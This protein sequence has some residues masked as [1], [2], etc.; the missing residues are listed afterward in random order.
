MFCVGTGL[1]L[2]F[3]GIRLGLGSVGIGLGLVWAAFWTDACITL[4]GPLSARC[5]SALTERGFFDVAACRELEDE[6]ELEDPE[7]ETEESEFSFGSVF[8]PVLFAFR[9]SF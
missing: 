4:G 3:G 5:G 1:G 2:G 9:D 8:W 6:L 7:D